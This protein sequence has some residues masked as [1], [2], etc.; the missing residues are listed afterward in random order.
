MGS[1]HKQWSSDEVP[2]S[3]RT[4]AWEEVLRRSYRDWQVPKRL[5]ATFRARVQNHDF[6]GAGIVDTVC[7]P[8]IGE[9]T[10]QLVK[11]A[12]E[13]YLG[14]QLTTS[15]RE[16]F[17]IGDKTVEVS[18]GD[19]VVWTTDRAAQFEVL[20]RLHKVTLMMPWSLIK[21]RLPEYR[22]PPPAGRLDSRAGVGSL[23]ATH[24]LALSNQIATL[25]Q[26]VHGSVSR[27]TF[28]LLGVALCGMDQPGQRDSGAVVLNQVKDF[29]LKGLHDDSL[30]P[31]KIA[32][33]NRISLRYLHMLFERTDTTVSSYILKSR[34]HACKQ[35]LTDPAFQRLQISEIA[36]RWGFNSMSHFCRTFKE[37]Y[38]R[39][40][41]DMRRTALPVPPDTPT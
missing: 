36:F 5:P 16:R 24:L 15:G 9:R 2:L 31:R 10:P 21:E 38:G 20:E 26:N 17:T 37:A 39:S 41:G 27:S 8:C 1:L 14:V 25:D 13:V 22:M 34:L 12:D 6:A 3:E 4:D 40:P 7:D 28:E 29:I 30:T 19:L 35:A 18:S 33:A 11:R 23:L 32:E